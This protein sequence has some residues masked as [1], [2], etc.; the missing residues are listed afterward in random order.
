[1]GCG[2]DG[3]GEGEMGVERSVSG[4]ESAEDNTVN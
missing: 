2:Q 4:A 1:M 3:S